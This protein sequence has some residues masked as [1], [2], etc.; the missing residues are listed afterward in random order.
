MPKFAAN[1]SMLFTEVDFPER[2]AAAAAA[3]FEGVE[4]LFP[5]AWSAD[6]LAGRL[7]EA[8]LAQVLFNLPPGDWE[9]GERGLA[10]IPGRQGEFRD[11]VGRAIEYARV[12]GCSQV[13]CMAGVATPDL[14]GAAMEEAYVDNLGWAAAACAEAGVRLLIEPLNDRDVPGYLLSGSD[15]ARRVI[16]A[17]NSDN[18]FLQFDVYHMQ[19]MEG[20]LATS[21]AANM[22]IIHHFQIAGVPDRHEPSRGEV[23]YPFLFA[24]IDALGYDG[25]I[26]CEYRPAAATADGLGWLAPWGIGAPSQRRRSPT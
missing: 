12:L 26:G 10:A 21:I 4:F 7:H 6:D 13:H 24:H 8:G 17:V 1:L 11:G 19:I 5:Y 22:D 14:D 23:N 3:G 15:Q 20:D 18:L 2:F 25:W 16:E 9:A